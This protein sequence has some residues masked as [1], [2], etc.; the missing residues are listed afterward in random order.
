MFPNDLRELPLVFTVTNLFKTVPKSLKR[1][2][3]PK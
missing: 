1:I 2:M 3:F